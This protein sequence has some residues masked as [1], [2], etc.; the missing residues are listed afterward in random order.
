VPAAARVCGRSIAEIVGSNS[1]GGMDVC[2]LWM[3]C[4]VWLRSVRKTDPPSRGVLASVVCLFRNLDNDVA[5]ARVEL[6]SYN[7]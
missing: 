5:W 1:A 6:L 3:L 4:A 2:L 7:K